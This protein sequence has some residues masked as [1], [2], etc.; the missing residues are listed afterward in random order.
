MLTCRRSAC[1]VPVAPDPSASDLVCCHCTHGCFACRRRVIGQAGIDLLAL[2]VLGQ[3]L[4][5]APL[6]LEDADG[7]LVVVL[8]ITVLISRALAQQ[9]QAAAL[10]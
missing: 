2:A 8:Q 6:Q 1:N 5:K 4:V 7:S 9:T 10:P 3:D